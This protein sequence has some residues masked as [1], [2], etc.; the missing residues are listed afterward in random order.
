M[1]VTN[2]RSDLLERPYRGEH[3]LRTI[4]SM[5]KDDRGMLALAMV[6]YIIKHSP[7]WVMPLLTA[8]VIDILSQPDVHSLSELWINGLVM[9][10]ML[11][12]NLPT[13]YIYVRS[14][15]TAI[16][17]MEAELRAALSRQLQNLSFG[18]YARSSSGAL[19]AKLLRDVE[20]IERL[21]RILL[22]Q[23]PAALTN[24]TAALIITATREPLFLLFFLL[25][26]PTAALLIRSLRS[27]LARRNAAFRHE[28][29][30]MS[31]RM[32]EMIQLLPITRAHGI[33]DYEMDRIS[34]KLESV[35]SAGIQ[36]DSINAIFNASSWIVFRCFEVACLL[37]A[38][39]MRYTA[40]LPISVGDVVLFT[41][42]FSAITN[43][44]M[45]LAN[46]LPEI[47]KGFESVR[48]VGEILECPD[49]EHNAGKRVVQSVRGCFDFEHVSYSY[50]DAKL[51]TVHD[52]SLH[53][54][55]GETIAI[56]GASGAGKSTLLNLVIGFLRPSSGRILLDGQDMGELDLRTYR[57]FLSVVSQE[58]ILFDGT[59]E[60]NVAYGKSS[61]TKESLKQ[62]L[63]SANAL[64]FVEQM[65]DGLDT[66]VGERGAR[67]SGGQKQRLAIA[68]ALIRNPRVL[69]L[70]EAT[71]ALDSVSETQVQEALE[72]LMKGRTTFVVAHRLSTVRKASRIVVLEQGRIVETGSHEELVGRGGVYAELHKLQYAGES[73]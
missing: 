69:I 6:F 57:R 36:L 46:M 67:L 38:A 1:S 61:V 39:W 41:G 43:A 11:V 64:E 27:S 65:P 58:T 37:T 54:E 50:P 31:S 20:V 26:V 16:R 21:A 34:Q 3:P 13:H 2:T 56:V 12:Q 8:N 5:Y 47:S 30:G 72:R 48:S 24:M 33:E 22:E 28:I 51:A 10:L 40:F 9:V 60:E 32:A 35:R 14:I 55:P 71:S 29:E 52:L 53:V 23:V 44:V 63:H 70:D 73:A 49:I 66:L 42:Y 15:S 18:F 17:K 62:A 59:V 45:Q 25:T 68:R 19:Q 4:L 7:A